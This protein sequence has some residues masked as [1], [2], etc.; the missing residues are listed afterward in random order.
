[1]NT[2]PFSELAMEDL[3]MLDMHSIDVDGFSVIPAQL[4]L[5]HNQPLFFHNETRQ[6]CTFAGITTAGLTIR[7]LDGSYAHGVQPTMVSNVGIQA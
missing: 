2:Q 7:Y 3:F 5:C 6:W 1:M 4:N